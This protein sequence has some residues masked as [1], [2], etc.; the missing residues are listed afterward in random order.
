MPIIIMEEAKNASS[1]DVLAQAF[2]QF[3]ESFRL[4]TKIPPS[5]R[6]SNFSTRY[7]RWKR[8]YR[9]L[10]LF[11]SNFFNCKNAWKAFRWRCFL[12]YPSNGLPFCH[13]DEAFIF[14]S[15]FSNCF[16]R[17]NHVVNH[18]N[19]FYSQKNSAINSAHEGLRIFSGNPNSFG[20]RESFPWPPP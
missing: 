8:I 11:C 15:Q 5:I 17:G 14:F 16:P 7:K 10:V 4:S 2:K 19:S 6:L 18:D 20:I 3:Q 1:A 9:H 12:L 13:W